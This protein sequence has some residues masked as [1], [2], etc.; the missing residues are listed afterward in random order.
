MKKWLKKN[1]FKLIFDTGGID[2]IYYRE[3]IDIYIERYKSIIN[4][5][6]IEY[7]IKQNRFLLNKKNKKDIKKYIKIIKKIRNG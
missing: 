1:E 5:G 6:K 7:S 3:D 4:Y 2:K